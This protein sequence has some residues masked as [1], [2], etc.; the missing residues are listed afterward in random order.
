MP[1]LLLLF[2]LTLPPT[3][4]TAAPPV[5]DRPVYAFMPQLL[6][7]RVLLLSPAV[8]FNVPGP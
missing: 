1:K 8:A 7:D 2:A 3:A 4:V 6:P 5:T